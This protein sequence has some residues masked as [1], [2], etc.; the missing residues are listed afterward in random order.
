[1][2]EEELWEKGYTR[3]GGVDEAGRGPLAGPLVAS[4]VVISPGFS[5]PDLRD[6]KKLSPTKRKELFEEICLRAMSIGVSVVGEKWIDVLGIQKANFFAFQDAIRRAF[7]RES[8]DFLILDWWKIPALSI[9]FLSFS[10]A[11]D[12]SVAV[13]SASI[14]AKVVRDQLMEDFYHPL[15]PQY[16]FSSHKGYG[17][18]FHLTQIA[19]WGLSPYHRKSFC[20]SYGKNS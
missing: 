2:V 15:F 19:I 4:C 1:M 11:E 5:L 8:P 17:T 16:G 18:Q 9:P 7:L 3:I 6:S 12:L 14:V 20:A 13:A 10:H